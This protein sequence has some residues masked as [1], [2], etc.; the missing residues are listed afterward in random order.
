MDVLLDNDPYASSWG[1]G[2]ASTYLVLN[3][4]T[5]AH[6]FSEKIN[7]YVNQKNGASNSISFFLQ[8]FSSKHLYGNYENGVQVA[9]RIIYVRLFALLAFFILLIACINFMNLSTAKATLKL[10]E[11]GVKKTFGAERGALII[12]FLGES[13]MMVF[14]ATVLAFGLVYLGLP[15][16]NA[17]TDKSLDLVLQGQD[18]L[19]IMGI[20]LGTGLLAGVYPAIYLSGFKPL[21]VLKGKLNK[22]TGALWLRKGLVTFQFALSLMFLLGLIIVNKQISFIQNKNLGYNRNNVISFLW[23]GELY[24]QWN[25]LGEEGNSNQSFETFMAELRRIPGVAYASNMGGDILDEVYGQS[26]VDWE[27]KKEGDAGFF[28]SPVIGYDLIETLGIELKEGRTFSEAYDDDYS[29][30]IL[31]EKAVAMMGLDDPLNTKI[32]V[33]SGADQVIGVVSNFHYGSLHQAIQPLIFR[34]D[35]H[36]RNILIKMNAGAE[37]NTLAEIKKLHQ[38]ILPG[39]EFDYQFM[40]EEYAQLYAS[41]NRVAV[42][43]KYLAAIAI[44]ISCLGLLGLVAFSAE[45][46]AKEISIRRV[47]GAS[48]LGIL[49]LLSKDY[50]KLI[51]LSIFVATPLTYLL[52]INWLNGFVEHIELHWAY[53]ILSACVLLLIAGITICLQSLKVARGNLRDYLQGE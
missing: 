38:K 51:F 7:Q 16:M 25:G 35:P 8:P 18:I 40:D 5:A 33:N 12:Q 44:I 27:G 32:R 22:A 41:E 29:K 20:V 42:L 24:D 48:F 21:S 3:E 37:R 15:Q 45:R 28:K 23:K 49:G 19:T 31:N 52:A 30:V 14:M 53:F 47:L 43:S 17:I 9:G 6:V 50:A 4:G 1:G 46:R 34:F 39:F 2:Y 10:K 13:I 36:G 26:G 11:I